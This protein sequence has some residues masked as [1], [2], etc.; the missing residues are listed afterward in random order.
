MINMLFEENIKIQFLWISRYWSGFQ[1]NWQYLK[2]IE[3]FILAVIAT[4]IVE[5]LN[6]FHFHY[7]VILMTVLE[8]KILE[9]VFKKPWLWWRY[10]DDIFM[11]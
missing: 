6:S 4:K 2:N 11:I 5:N 8:E 9:H 3:S 1:K 10:T 7:A